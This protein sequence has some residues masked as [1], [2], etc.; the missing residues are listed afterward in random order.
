M[1]ILSTSVTHSEISLTESSNL[2]FQKEFQNV[3]QELAISVPF[4]CNQKKE[5]K[6]GKLVWSGYI[7]L[8][9]I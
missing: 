8:K 5:K 4:M 9:I 1:D 6:M 3:T 2:V 7:P